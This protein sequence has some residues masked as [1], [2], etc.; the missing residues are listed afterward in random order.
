MKTR[1]GKVRGILVF[2]LVAAVVLAGCRKKE[3]QQPEMVPPHGMM[4]QKHEAVVVVPDSVKGKWKSV[5]IDVLDKSTL[6]KAEYEIAIG[7]EAQVAGSD[8]TIRVDN[9]MPDF[10]MNGPV[11]TSA[12]NEPKKPAA[13]I[14]IMEKG[15]EIFKGWVFYNLPSPHDFQHPKYAVSLAGFVPASK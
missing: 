14:R 6:K 7:S 13:Q 9:F 8:L 15:Q 4:E 2:A 11:R 5:K 10:I 3:E 1:M 12:S